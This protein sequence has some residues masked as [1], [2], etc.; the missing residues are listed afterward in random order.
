MSFSKNIKIFI[1]KAA[2]KS[3]ELSQTCGG[4]TAFYYIFK[5]I[6]LELT[7]IVLNIIVLRHE[8][9]SRV[10]TLTRDID[11]ASLSVCPSVTFRY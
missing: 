3:A 4:Q 8:F 5:W 11:I 7:L 1:F 6:T 2:Y 10:S 9:L